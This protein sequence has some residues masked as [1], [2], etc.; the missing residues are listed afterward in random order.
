MVRSLG[1]QF[2]ITGAL[3]REAVVIDDVPVK[4][5]H[6]IIRHGVQSKHY[7]RDGQIMARRV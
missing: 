4:N 2:R 5:V 3:V 1:G 6:F 7:I